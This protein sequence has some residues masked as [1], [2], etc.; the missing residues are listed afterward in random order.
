MPSSY[1]KKNGGF[2]CY[3][4]YISLWNSFGVPCVL[5]LFNRYLKNQHVDKKFIKL[6]IIII[7]YSLFNI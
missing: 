6:F 5:N 7:I 1:Y 2:P 4:I 3:D